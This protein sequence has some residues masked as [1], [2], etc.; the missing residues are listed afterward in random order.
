[1]HAIHNVN[2]S[3]LK[4]FVKF[5]KVSLIVEKRKTERKIRI[6]SSFTVPRFEVLLCISPKF[7]IEILFEYFMICKFTRFPFCS[8]SSKSQHKSELELVG[9]H[10]IQENWKIDRDAYP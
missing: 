3:T 4:S 9:N 10:C 1:M 7:L 5:A 2:N 6:R 8:L